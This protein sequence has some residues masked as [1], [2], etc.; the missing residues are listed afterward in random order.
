MALSQACPK[1]GSRKSRTN[2]RH[3]PNVIPRNGTSYGRSEFAPTLP[4]SR[5]QLVTAQATLDTFEA[6]LSKDVSSS[7]V[8]ALILTESFGPS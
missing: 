5:L 2:T 8:L 3:R 4:S 1:I 7:W 6:R